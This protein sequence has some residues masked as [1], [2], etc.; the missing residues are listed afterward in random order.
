MDE[1][2]DQKVVKGRWIDVLTNV[3]DDNGNEFS[4]HHGWVLGKIA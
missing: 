2:D 3:R 4:A 1:G